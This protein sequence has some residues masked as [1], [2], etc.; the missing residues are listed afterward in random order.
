[1]QL[2]VDTELSKPAKWALDRLNQVFLSRSESVQ[3]R[4]APESGH[5][6]LIGVADRSPLVDQALDTAGLQCPE[7]SES[8]VIHRVDEDRLLVAGRDK[9]GLVYA[10][11]EVARTIELS[12]RDSS[13]LDGVQPAVESPALD[14]RSMQLF[15][16]NRKLEQEWFYREDFWEAYLTQ[17][18]RDRFNNLSLTFAHQTNYL[19]PPYPFFVEMPEFPQVVPVDF[20]TEEREQNLDML[21]KISEMARDRALHFTFAV[22]TQNADSYGEPTVMGLD[23][24]NLVD[25]NA[26]GLRRVLEACPRIDGVQFRMNSESGIPEDRQIEFYEKQF[27]AVAD[28]GRPLRLDLRAK[29]LADETIQLSREIVPSTV[30]ST[31]HWCE[32]QGLPYPMPAIQKRDINSYRRYGMWDLL[33]KPRAYPLVYRLWSAGSQRVLL[34]GDPEWVKRFATSCRFGGI[35]FEVMAPLTNK[36]FRADTEPW[37]TI[38]N[39]E[40]QP[41]PDE[42]QRY[43]MFNLLFGRLGYNPETSAEI[44]E[45]ELRARFGEAAEAVGELYRGGGKILP[46]ITTVLQFSAS[47]WGFWPE[48]FAGRSLEED[49]LIEPSD[50]TQFYRVDEYV[51]DAVNGRLCGKWTPPHTA[52]HFRKLAAETRDALSALGTESTSDDAELRGTRLDFAIAADLADYHACRLL[53]TTHLAFYHQTQNA[54]HLQAAREALQQAEP[55]WASLSDAADGV[56]HPYLIFGRE[57][58]RGHWKDRLKVVAADLEAIDQLME[59]SDAAPAPNPF[60]GGDIHPD[61]PGITFTP[62]SEATPD[63]DLVLRI[64]AKSDASLETVRCY[65]KIVNQVLPFDCL[66]MSNQGDDGYTVTIPGTSIDARWDM[67][68]FFEF[69]YADDSA[70]RWP[71][72]RQHTPYVVIPV[73]TGHQNP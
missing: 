17:L 44:W 59:K 18:V 67:M 39:P 54:A 21:R 12:D 10:L 40:Y 7:A 49:I 32:H 24:E 71:D 61:P 15:L 43:W 62:P 2:V 65:Y 37:Q 5:A 8:L 63:H 46:L 60:A 70:C 26:V 69:V 3:E 23:E 16:C 42:I 1:M 30:I 56:Y 20:S 73:A 45:R 52:A 4:S 66:D 35:G 36:G 57:Q 11:L 41:Y 22:W 6:I 14:W 28:C 51:E 58:H 19:A 38:D 68:V 29:G 9:R 53:A 48:M 72:W 33:Q 27:R 34:W 47:M 13:P 31:K 50:P 64:Q 25:F 55:H